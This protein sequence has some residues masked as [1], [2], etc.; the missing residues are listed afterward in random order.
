MVDITKL[1]LTEG[2]ALHD[3]LD[4][5]ERSGKGI[6]LVL[7]DEGRL[8]CTITDG[9]VRRAVLRGVSLTTPIREWLARPEH[10]DRPVPI[11]A[12]VGTDAAEKVALMAS[13]GVRHLP[14]LD[15]EGR[16]A[17]VA[18]LDEMAVEGEPV[19]RAVVMAGGFGTRLHPLTL[20]TPKPMLPVG[21]RPI[22][23]HMLRQIRQAGIHQVNITTHYLPQRIV[24]HFQTGESFDV[25]IQYVHEESPRGTAGALARIGSSSEPVL[26][27]NGD[28][29]TRLDFRALVAFHREHRAAL[30]VAVR[31]EEFQVPYGVV[32][33]EGP[34]LRSIREKP[35]F[36]YFVNAGIYLLEPHVRELV[37]NDTRFDMTDLMQ[38]CLDAGER[39]VAFP[40]VEYWRD[41]GRPDDYERAQG[42]Q[43]R[44]ELA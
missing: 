37:P 20:D 40:V 9:D 30:T 10:V 18:A 24:D 41:I 4:S 36:T 44:T 32:T 25:A 14:L 21:D 6:V 33:L 2:H 35:V 19:P 13:H 15:A 28:I 16:V 3:A 8:R 43:Q 23:E 1:A 39:V 31:S 29:L 5:L 26:V 22:M 17:D 12:L 27:V 42:E 11:T 38:A 7:D 34:E